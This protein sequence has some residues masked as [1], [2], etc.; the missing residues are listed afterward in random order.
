MDTG[1]PSSRPPRLQRPWPPELERVAHL[2]QPQPGASQS[3]PQAESLTLS[4]VWSMPSLEAADAAM[5][6]PDHGFI[7]R[8]DAHP[9]ARALAMKLAAAHGAH[10]CVLTAQGM[11]ALAAVAWSCL[12]PGN[13]VWLARDLYGKTRAMFTQGLGPWNLFSRTFDPTSSE[14]VQRLASGRPDL[15]VIETIS[16]PRLVVSDIAGIAE[17]THKLGGKLL[18]DNTFASHLIARPLCMGADL[19]MESLTKIV[20]GHSDCMVGMLCGLEG[21]LMQRIASA[22]SL[23]GLASSPLDCYLTSRGLSTLPLRLDAACRNA[24]ALAQELGAHAQVLRV[25][26]PG[27]ATHPQHALAS[28]QLT[29][30]GWMLC[31]EIDGGRAE[32]GRVIHSL[33]PEI[34]FGPS[35]GDIQTTVSHP[36]STSHRALSVA[37]LEELGISQGTLR[38]SCGAEP[39]DWLCEKFVQAL[40]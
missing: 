34:P 14:D 11:S 8:R 7:Y 23:Y 33:Q 37:E 31:I 20:S 26:Y 4:S 16:N 27:L 32:V 13:E 22:V 17:V 30:Y 9:N 25:D 5:Q 38:I 3:E 29:A 1:D 28:R 12:K 35:L 24:L 2:H 15:V 19:C 39:T 36:A 40:K 21:A 10:S 6:D 18:V